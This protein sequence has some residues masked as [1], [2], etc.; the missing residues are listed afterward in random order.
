M[1]PLLAGL[2]SA[3]QDLQSVLGDWSGMSMGDKSPKQKKRAEKQKQETKDDK[4]RR[5]AAATLAKQVV[6]GDKKKP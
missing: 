5:A 6:P 4:K 2:Q 3:A 1:L